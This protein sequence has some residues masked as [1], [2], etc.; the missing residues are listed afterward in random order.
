M[1]GETLQTDFIFT[2]EN[3]LLFTTLIDCSP[4]IAAKLSL[5]CFDKYK[6]TRVVLYK[7]FLFIFVGK[8]SA[9]LKKIVFSL[10]FAKIS[11]KGIAA[12]GFTT[13]V[14]KSCLAVFA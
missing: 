3:V 7:L 12:W 1:S 9:K 14:Q 2:Q 8:S 4:G 6:Y 5:F 10:S 11:F 13:P